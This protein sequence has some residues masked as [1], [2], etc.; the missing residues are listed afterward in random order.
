MSDKEDSSEAD[1]GP[2]GSTETRDCG[3]VSPQADSE[4]RFRALA[5]AALNQQ[6]SE[7]GKLGRL[8]HDD[9]AQMLSAAGMQLDILSM[10][11]RETVPEIASRTTE[12][13]K[14]LDHV[15]QRIRD[16]SYEL[17]PD[18]V[19][20][21][22]LQ[23]ALDLLVGRFRKSFPGNLRL[24]YDSA[25]HIGVAA[26]VAMER[27]AEE[28]VANAVRHAQCK[29]IEILVTSTREGEILQVRD[30]GTGF[31]VE[32]AR[33]FPRGLGLARLE[34]CAAKA[35]LRLTVSGKAGKGTTVR[36]VLARAQEGGK[37]GGRR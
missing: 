21:I 37:R 9:V 36:A 2:T 12:I 31:D 30:D 18:I 34:Y 28:A 7:R 10:D 3:A 19:E 13:Q 16:L 1:S 20:R 26:G 25:V 17:D 27:I 33:A 15:V 4:T 11:L 22:G 23:V 6:Q 8:L 24:M 35:G 29:Q 32:H 14:M 5:L